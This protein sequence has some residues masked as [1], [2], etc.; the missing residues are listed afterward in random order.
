MITKENL[1]KL[2]KKF[3]HINCYTDKKCKSIK[4]SLFSKTSKTMKTVQK[5]FKKNSKNLN[6]PNDTN[7]NATVK[8][9][10]KINQELDD[11]DKKEDNS[12]P[13]LL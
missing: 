13:Y 10:F 7:R 12:L 3:S 6:S 9:F 1:Q 5:I 11:E 8:S 4:K 2:K